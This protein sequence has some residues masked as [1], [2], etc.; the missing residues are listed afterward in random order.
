MP[1]YCVTP[2]ARQKTKTFLLASNERNQAFAQLVRIDDAV[3]I[4]GR[5]KQRPNKDERNYVKLIIENWVNRCLRN[6]FSSSVCSRSLSAITLRINYPS[7]LRLSE[8]IWHQ[9]FCYCYEFFFHFRQSANGNFTACKNSIRNFPKNEDALR[10]GW[11]GLLLPTGIRAAR[12]VYTI[13]SL[14][15]SKKNWNLKNSL[16]K[17]VR[18][19]F[20][21]SLL[22]R[23][24]KRTEANGSH[25]QYSNG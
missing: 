17:C 6:G 20:I 10:K 2:L 11:V 4:D 16:N 7:E 18:W 14:W 12:S 13:N 8:N 22:V 23:R 3:L 24:A 19:L 25:H 9:T 21:Y 15:S 5:S 1:L